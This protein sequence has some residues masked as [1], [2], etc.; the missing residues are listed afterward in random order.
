MSEKNLEPNSE[1]LHQHK[2]EFDG[3]TFSID[4][5]STSAN[6]FEVATNKSSRR[7]ERQTSD[8]RFPEK[9]LPLNPEQRKK[10][11]ETM[12]G[13]M[14]FAKGND[15]QQALTKLREI[16]SST[17]KETREKSDL[18]YEKARSLYQERT[19]ANVG[20]KDVRQQ[21]NILVIDTKPADYPVYKEFAKP[22][23]SPEVIEFASSICGTSMILITKDGWLIVQHRSNRNALYGDILGASVSG[24][25]QGKMYRPKPQDQQTQERGT[26]SPVD[27]DFVKKNIIKEMEEEIGLKEEDIDNLRIVALAKNKVQIH[28]DFLHL[29]TTN[30]TLEQIQEKASKQ[31]VDPKLR[32]VEFTE[33][34]IGIPATPDAIYKLLTQAH[35]PLAPTHCAIFI[36][37]GYS[38]VLEKQGKEQADKWMKILEINLSNNYQEI[39][40]IVAR[41]YQDHPEELDNI[42]EGK[43]QRNPH[44]YDPAYLPSE[45]GLPDAISELKRVGLTN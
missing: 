13:Q 30:L 19:A 18:E 1:L 39:D 24:F 23:A 28:Y 26:L 14:M 12:V 45:Q 2:P 37:A 17:P 7:R 8:P 40:Q 33:K 36:A 42:P 32:D 10:L 6:G 20:I 4:Y 22:N 16:Q 35:C 3:D 21:E 31:S 27:T 5:L 15:A 41:Y 25:L 29:G 43:S 34:F 11:K 38:M 44:G 9:E